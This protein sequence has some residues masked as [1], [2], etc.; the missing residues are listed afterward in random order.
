MFAGGN[1][2]NREAKRQAAHDAAK[3]C[4]GPDY[5]E[6]FHDGRHRHGQYVT[7]D[8]SPRNSNQH[9]RIHLNNRD[10]ELQDRHED[11]WRGERWV[12]AFRPSKRKAVK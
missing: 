2:D 5:W 10:S 8:P 6:P 12:T 11:S 3:D 1:S 4:R 7:S 9:R